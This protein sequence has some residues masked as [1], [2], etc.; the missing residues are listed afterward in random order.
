MV[1]ASVGGPVTRSTSPG[2]SVAK[3]LPKPRSARRA[4]VLGKMWLRTSC[5]VEGEESEKNMR[6]MWHTEGKA[7]QEG[8]MRGQK[9]TRKA[10]LSRAHPRQH[11]LVGQQLGLSDA[12]GLQ[13]RLEGCVGGDQ[14][15]EHLGGGGEFVQ[16]AQSLKRRK[17]MAVE[18]QIGLQR[19]SNESR[20]SYNTIHRA[21]EKEVYTK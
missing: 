19:N 16:Q 12:V 17:S 3:P 11:G 13:Q 1:M 14:S 15:S 10:E 4:L 7:E 20:E 21:R 9:S 2:L 5:H 18:D 8:L 6:G